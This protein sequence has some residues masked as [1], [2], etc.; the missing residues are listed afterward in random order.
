ME[1]EVLHFPEIVINLDSEADLKAGAA[2]VVALVKPDWFQDQFRYKLF[3]DGISNKLIGV[4]VG[5][6]KCDMVLV[7]VYGAKTELIIDRT[8]EIRNMLVMNKVGCGCQLYAKF[9]NGLAYEF[10]PG[11]TLTIE[12]A[13]S[14]KIYPL[15][16]IHI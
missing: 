11:E 6:K 14:E 2:K 4:Y 10:L 12:T 13:K 16:L 5:D 9:G 8:A 1:D 3:T 15:S 7:R